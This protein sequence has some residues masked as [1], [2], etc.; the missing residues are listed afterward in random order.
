MTFERVE[1]VGGVPAAV[2]EQI[3]VVGADEIAV[4]VP[5]RAI[6]QRQ[7]QSPDPRQ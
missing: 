3:A 4:D 5:E 7:W 1:R 2:H 6:A